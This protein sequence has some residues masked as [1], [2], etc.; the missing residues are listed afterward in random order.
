MLRYYNKKQYYNINSKYEFNRSRKYD[1]VVIIIE[2]SILKTLLMRYVRL[3]K[4]F[5]I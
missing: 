3:F 2:K 1:I 4:K 5:Q